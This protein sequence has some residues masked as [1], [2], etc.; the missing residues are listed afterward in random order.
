MF[1]LSAD[2]VDV[3]NTDTL[4]L[5]TKAKKLATTFEF[6]LWPNVLK[7]DADT[8]KYGECAIVVEE[9]VS[10]GVRA[11]TNKLLLDPKA[12]FNLINKQD[13]N[14]ETLLPTIVLW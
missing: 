1:R 14:S 7:F 9:G 3:D 8:S 11:T 13:F 10:Q 2:I 4:N 5:N 12:G 6:S